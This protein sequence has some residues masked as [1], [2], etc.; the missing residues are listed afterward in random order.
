MKAL[1]VIPIF[2][3]IAS[4]EIAIG[5]DRS[6]D[7][8]I[9]RPCSLICLN[10]GSCQLSTDAEVAQLGHPS[11]YCACPT[12]YGG[13]TC[14]YIAEQCGFYE[15]GLADLSDIHEDEPHS[16]GAADGGA[17]AQIDTE[18]IAEEKFCLHGAP[19]K[20]TVDA[21]TQKQIHAC[22]CS[23][24]IEAG[25]YAGE[26]CQHKAT[27]YCRDG[28]VQ[29]SSF[30]VNGGTC[31][32]KN[33]ADSGTDGHIGCDCPSAFE[34]DFC[35]YEK[36]LNMT[37]RYEVM[38][39]PKSEVASIILGSVLIA[40]LAGVVM[41]TLYVSFDGC[42]ERRKNRSSDASTADLALDPD[43]ETLKEATREE[44][45]EGGEFPS[46]QQEEASSSSASSSNIEFA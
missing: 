40:I 31:K 7:G 26:A 25:A 17:A 28:K 46:K 6:L 16:D 11:Q 12:G 3:W 20:M 5:G 24:A 44:E 42:R 18:L 35:E 9:D 10:G 34:G 39:R 21:A 29:R 2:A 38:Q 43:G 45:G 32:A 27:S 23:Q 41:A 22:D 14:E 30:C 4:A 13:I 36:G 1:C 15:T 8:D 33:D 19:C 37:H